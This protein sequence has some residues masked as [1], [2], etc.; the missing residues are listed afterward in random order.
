M[1]KALQELDLTLAAALNLGLW[2]LP[3][4][5]SL[6]S[7]IIQLTKLGIRLAKNIITLCLYP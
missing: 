2:N 1:Y 4:S 3:I 7:F 5:V 6:G